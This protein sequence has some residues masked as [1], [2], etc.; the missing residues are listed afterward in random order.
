MIWHR[1][2]HFTR[3]SILTH[4]VEKH[5]NCTSTGG[6]HGGVQLTSRLK[7]KTTLHYAQCTVFQWNSL[8]NVLIHSLHTDSLHLKN[9]NMISERIYCLRNTRS[10]SAPKVKRLRVFANGQALSATVRLIEHI[11][12]FRPRVAIGDKKNTSLNRPNIARSF[13]VYTRRV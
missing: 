4:F 1:G 6:N 9:N 7:L 8:P 2:V 5:F 13:C 3:F 10:I 12:I 11:I